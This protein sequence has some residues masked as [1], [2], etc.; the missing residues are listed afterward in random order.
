MYVCIY[1]QIVYCK[2]IYIYTYVFTYACN[3]AFLAVVL[4]TAAV[5]F[6]NAG[7]C[8]VTAAKPNRKPSESTGI[9]SAAFCSLLQAPLRSHISTPAQV[10]DAVVEA[11]QPGTQF[12]IHGVLKYSGFLL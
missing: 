8:H 2:Y 7:D 9:T 5:L 12:E 11:Y 10:Y 1:I 3:V 4:V 6:N